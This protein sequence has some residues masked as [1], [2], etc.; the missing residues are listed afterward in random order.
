MLST[1]EQVLILR[2]V[3]LFSHVPDEVLA[4]VALLLHEMEVKPGETIV[5][6]GETGDCLYI[7]VDGKVRVHDG[8]RTLNHLGEGAVFGEMAVL[9]AEPRSASVTAVEETRLFRLDQ[10]PLYELMADRIEVARGI[11]HVL[12][13]NMRARMRD[14]DDLRTRLEGRG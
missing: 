4:E 8:E 12:T 3:G 7:L 11:I 13:A 6:K 5:R 9:D 2:T 14:L 1:I 10:D